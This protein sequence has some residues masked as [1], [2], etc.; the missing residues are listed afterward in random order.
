MIRTTTPPPPRPP[1]RSYRRQLATAVTIGFGAGLALGVFPSSA[2]PH[3]EPAE[4][5]AAAAPPPLVPGDPTGA[6]GERGRLVVLESPVDTAR[7]TRRL[8][9]LA[10]FLE[11]DEPT[12][13]V[14]A[15]G[16]WAATARL[17]DGAV[18]ALDCR[19]AEMAAELLVPAPAAAPGA[20][21]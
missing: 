18:L 19:D 13:L 5:V 9:H 17:P 3:R 12:P 10:A 1:R 11:G 6:L 4:V 7:C 20:W 16:H 2:V 8:L 15:P 21:P 14:D